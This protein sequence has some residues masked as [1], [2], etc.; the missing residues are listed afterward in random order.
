MI[1]LGS[2]RLGDAVN[3]FDHSLAERSVRL[4]FEIMAAADRVSIKSASFGLRY[5]ECR[6]FVERAGQDFGGACGR[7]EPFSQRFVALLLIEDD[8]RVILLAVR[9]GTGSRNCIRLSV[10]GHGAFVCIDHLAILLPG[11]VDDH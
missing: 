10:L 3:K 8:R 1:S 6:R 11:G 7:Q 9:T 4:L 5:A 2:G